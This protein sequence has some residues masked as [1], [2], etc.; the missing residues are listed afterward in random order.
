MLVLWRK[1]WHYRRLSPNLI[2]FTVL[3]IISP[4]ILSCQC[5]WIVCVCVR[6]YACARARARVCV[7]VLVRHIITS[8]DCKSSLYVW[9]DIWMVLKNKKQQTPCS[10]SANELYW[11]SDRHLSAKLVPTFAEKGCHVVSMTD[12]YGRILG[13]VDRSRYFFFQVEE[14]NRPCSRPTTSQKI[15]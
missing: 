7:C 2:C 1:K 15:W 5:P 8:S 4:Y 10:E 11:S 3:N 13:F 9:L 6:A 14:L 12:P